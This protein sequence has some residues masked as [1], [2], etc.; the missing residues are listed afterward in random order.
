VASD[1]LVFAIAIA[2]RAA[3]SFAWAS[4]SDAAASVTALDAAVNASEAS[5][6]FWSMSLPPAIAGVTKSESTKGTANNPRVNREE[7][8]RERKARTE[9]SVQREVS[10]G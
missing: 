9:C 1:S 2:S 4:F 8:R 3:G 7:L 6:T 5:E 10:S